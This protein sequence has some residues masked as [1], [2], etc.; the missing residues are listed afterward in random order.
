M[1]NEE[2][3]KAIEMRRSRRTY[4]P[5]QLDRDILDVIQ[6][7]VDLVNEKANLNFQLVEDGTY[8]FTIFTGKFSYIAVCGPDTERARILSGYWGE[9]IVLQC[10]YH[11][12]GTCW[13]TG[14]YDENKVYSTINL[15]QKLRLYGVIVIGYVKDKLSTK[16]KI[17]YNATHK[18]NKPYQKMFDVCDEKLPVY[19]E[20]G[21]K[22]VEKAPSATNRRPVHF[23]YEN[24]IISASVDAPYSDKSLDFGIA[25]LHFQIGAAA[26]GIK[27]EWDFSGRFC[28]EDSKVIKF[29]DAEKEN[30]KIENIQ[31]ENKNE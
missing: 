5:K 27:G 14:S 11:G 19:Y 4:R 21:M 24:G 8:P 16:E 28:T 26:K 7:L 25:Q 17:I 31:E 15:P 12:L 1:T 3:I 22:L 18:T 20:Y 6:N 29:P 2:Y 23:K 13:V 30:N 10:V 9:M